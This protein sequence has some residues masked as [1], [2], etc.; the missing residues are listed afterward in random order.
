MDKMQ[1]IVVGEITFTETDTTV[2][3]T[4]ESKEIKDHLTLGDMP[5]GVSSM[6]PLET[7]SVISEPTEGGAATELTTT[8]STSSSSASSN[9]L[10]GTKTEEDTRWAKKNRLKLCIIK[11]TELSSSDRE[12]WLSGDNSSSWTNRTTESIESS[13]SSGSRYNM[14]SRRNSTCTCPVRST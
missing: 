3:N 9:K 2:N 1:E 6:Q 11:Q 8:M 13:G 4:D 10:P 5:Q 14:R 12:K 7:S